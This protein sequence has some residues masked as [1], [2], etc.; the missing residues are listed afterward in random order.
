MDIIAQQEKELTQ[1]AIQKIKSIKD[2]VIY[3]SDLYDDNRLGVIAF[4]LEGIHHAL[5]STIL[6]YEAGIGV[7]HGCFCAHRYIKSLLGITEEQ[8]K[9]LKE[10]I[11]GSYKANLPGAVRISFGFYNTQEDVDRPVEALEKIS[12]K[13]FKG[14]YK[15]DPRWGEYIPEDF[16]FNYRQYFDF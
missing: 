5:V 6:S 10:E 4:N 8:S 12:R 1:Y 15:L 3:G 7:R 9:K 2:M 13:E 14:R 11:R 16:H